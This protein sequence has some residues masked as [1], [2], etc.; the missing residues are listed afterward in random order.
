VEKKRARAKAVVELAVTDGVPDIVDHV[1]AVHR[2]V[3]GIT[4]EL[5]RSATAEADDG[6]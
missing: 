3:N 6:P 2:V 5:W 4:Q 1:L